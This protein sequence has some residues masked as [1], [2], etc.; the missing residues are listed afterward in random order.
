MA[1]Q[2]GVLLRAGQEQVTGCAWKLGPAD[3]FERAGWVDR[4]EREGVSLLD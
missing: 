3:A 4:G 2:N 1:L